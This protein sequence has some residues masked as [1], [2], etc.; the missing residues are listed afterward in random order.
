MEQATTLH[1]AAKRGDEQALW[2]LLAAG[3]DVEAADAYGWLPI[4]A[5]QGGHVRIM[6]LLLKAD[7]TTAAAAC[8][9]GPHCIGLFLQCVRSGAAANRGSPSNIDRGG[10]DGLHPA[11]YRS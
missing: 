8:R 11:A 6:Q 1:E 5:A 3:A 7:P 4:H 10:Y 2:K 9:C